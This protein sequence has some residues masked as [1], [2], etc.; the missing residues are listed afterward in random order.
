[1]AKSNILD[2]LLTKKR[3][4]LAPSKELVKECLKPKML[5][6][7]DLGHKANDSLFKHQFK[8]TWSRVPL[9]D[10]PTSTDENSNQLIINQQSQFDTF[11]GPYDLQ[12]TIKIDIDAQGSNNVDVQST[13]L[14]IINHLSSQAKHL[15]SKNLPLKFPGSQV[16]GNFKRSS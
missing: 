15:Q 5:N 10:S 4:R 8:L 16:Y 3:P 11:S 9:L 2:F 7:N 13:F 12:E 1:M 14:G 6:F